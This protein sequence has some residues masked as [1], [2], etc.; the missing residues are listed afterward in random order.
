MGTGR[1]LVVLLVA[2]AS[3]GV[4]AA[5]LRVACVGAS[6]R[7]SAEAASAPAPF[8]SL[9]AD[10]RSLIGAG[11]SEERSPDVIGVT[12]STPVVSAVGG[13]MEVPWPSTDRAAIQA[14]KAPLLFVGSGIRSGRVPSGVTLDQVAPTLEPLLG[15]HRA[16][17][18]VRS[19]SAIEGIVDRAA[20]T[21]LV[22]LITWKGVGR[23]DE[24]AYHRRIMHGAI[25]TGSVP[26]ASIG[27]GKATSVEARAAP[28]MNGVGVAQGSASAGSLPLDPIAVEATI[29][30]GGLPSDHGIT[31]TKIADDGHAVTAFGPRAPQPVIATLGDDLNKATGGGT[32]IGLVATATGDAA[33]TGDDWYGGGRRSIVDRSL[34]VRPEA[35]VDISSFLAQG[36]GRDGVPDLLAVA[37]SGSW[38]RDTAT[39]SEIQADVFRAVPDATIVEAGTGSVT[40]RHEVRAPAPVGTDDAVGG[41]L[42]VEPGTSQDV[43]DALHAATAPD[44]S[45]LFADAF[46]SYAVQFGA[47]C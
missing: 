47:Y 27:G 5:V 16:H 30:T 9:P 15:L 4:P 45:R 33:L 14:T 37:L 24:T 35:N 46:A 32:K 38:Q 19:G 8:C 28:Y 34:R 22:V 43:V 18:D 26:S 36:W 6:C 42:F 23:S 11:Y 40:V 29:G 10:V 3:I 39:S 12:G 7:A 21:P 25:K 44:G 1:R 17:A 2:L 13:G 31:G 41:G 20:R